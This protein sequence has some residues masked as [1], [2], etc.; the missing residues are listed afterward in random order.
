MARHIACLTFDV[1]TWSGFIA[2]GLTTPTPISRGEF[3][4]VG[5]KR[6][7]SLLERY[8]I[9]ASWFIP[10]MVIAAYPEACEAIVAAGHEVGHH[11]WTHVPPADLAPG[12][13]A[14]EMQRA[15]EEIRRLT[16]RGA[17][18][19]RSPAWDISDRTVDLLL[20]HGFL[21]ESSMMGNDHCPY[22]VRKGDV[23]STTEPPVFGEKTSLI[24][25]PISW[26]LDDFPHFEFLRTPGYVLPGLTGGD[27]VLS[28]WTADFDFM[29][30]TED[31]G[32]LTYTFHPYVTGR[33]HRMLV[34][35]KL[36]QHLVNKN[37]VFM[38]ME[39]AAL[40][41][42]RKVKAEELTPYP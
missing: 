3:G 17:A 19:Y 11:G 23:I 6:I 24:E 33:G 20:Q 25:M 39:R 37:A 15:N 13:E 14:H 22:Y 26:S 40:E 9:K 21:Y 7:L 27:Q 36:I 41:F 38:T 16:G 8:D 31:W 35:E 28:N 10:G 29:A 32:V 2:K 18:G 1:D 12:V 5:I 42:S 34:L 30:Q 4:I